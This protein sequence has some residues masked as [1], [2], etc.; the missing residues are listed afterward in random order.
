MPTYENK[1]NLYKGW[2]AST[3][4]EQQEANTILSVGGI[5]EDLEE[6]VVITKY[7]SATSRR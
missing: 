4:L 5:R 6:T 1:G 3:D 2:W 7:Q